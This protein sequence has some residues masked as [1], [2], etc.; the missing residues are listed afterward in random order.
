MHRTSGKALEEHLET[1]YLEVGICSP[2]YQLK[3]HSQ[4]HFDLPKNTYVLVITCQ[5]LQALKDCV[6]NY[7][8]S[9]SAAATNL[10]DVVKGG[11]GFSRTDEQ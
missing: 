4:C 5:F 8:N 11:G 10:L 9:S 7:A 6:V 2:A 1:F 3:C